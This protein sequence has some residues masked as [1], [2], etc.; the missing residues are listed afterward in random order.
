MDNPYKDYNC[1]YCNRRS[2][3]TV[4]TAHYVRGFVLAYQVGWKKFPACVGCARAQ[5][6][7]EAGLSALIGW[8]SIT[9]LILNPL[10]IAF[11]ILKTPFVRADAAALNKMFEEAG[12][13]KPGDQVDILKVLYGLAAKMIAAD[14]KIDQREIAVAAE[15]GVR[16]S[17]GFEYGAF[18]EAVDSHKSLPPT[19][20]YAEILGQALQPDHKVLVLR[21]L[22]MIAMADGEMDR[23]EEKLLAE[24]RDHMGLKGV[25]LQEL[26]RPAPA[27][28]PQ[29]EAQPAATA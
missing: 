2:L 22:H 11:L 27:E 13:P 12:I 8:F 6:L 19:R 18:Q 25:D 4:A 15:Q 26:A 24:I 14:G 7:K 23:S 16:L 17:S 5:L 21:Y 20:E 28:S 9:C 10:F 1:P 29:A 3:E